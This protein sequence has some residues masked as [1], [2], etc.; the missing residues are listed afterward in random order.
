MQLTSFPKFGICLY[1]P[2]ELYDGSFIQEPPPK[3]LEFFPPPWWELS[4][5]LR[6]EVLPEDPGEVSLRH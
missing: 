2:D 1:V 3:G 6:L 5:T 4:W